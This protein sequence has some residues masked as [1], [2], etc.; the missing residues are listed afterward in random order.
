VSFLIRILLALVAATPLHA[1]QAPVRVGAAIS[2][3]GALAALAADYG[4]GLAL[5]QDEINAA[6]G[7]LGRTVELRIHDDGS[8][9]ARARELYAQL[10]G[11]EKVELL[12]G[13]FGTA[14][15][16]LAAGEAERARRVLI[17]GS[18]A[19]R[20]VHKR[21]PRYVFQTTV[22]NAAYGDAVL[23]VAGKSSVFILARDDPASREMAEATRE[24]ALK[25]GLKA[26][27]IEIYS[28]AASDFSAQVQKA[29]AAGADAWIA[30]GEVRD[31]AGMIRTFRKLGY[32][33]AIFFSR[34][35]GHP[36]LIEM[37]GQDAEFAL[38]AADYRADL[39]TPGNDRFV[40]NFMAKFGAPPSPAA[41]EGYAAGT[42]LAE[43]VRRA[44]TLEQ[45]KLRETLAKL[46]TG[47]VLGGYKVTQGGEQVAARPA[48]VQILKGRPEVVSPP[49]LATAE[50]QPYPPWSERRILK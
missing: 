6:G 40:Q 29:K 4:R 28:L 5:W 42:V 1:Q 30:F 8:D 39:R 37:L 32:A 2:Q 3:S 18:G 47:T 19:S 44:G 20:A 35:A 7:L 11:E 17:N 31:A 12:V 14:A 10:I 50:R 46:E 43:A 15:T 13:P 45:E 27:D 25:Q 26:G 22:P 24:V 34:A 41:A 9:A 38:G 36:R 48:V 49:P 16:L 23:D 33:P 21:E